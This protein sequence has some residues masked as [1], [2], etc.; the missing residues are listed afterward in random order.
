M[1]TEPVLGAAGFTSLI[2]ALF[3]LARIM[4]WVDLSDDQLAAWMAVV[5]IAA[6]M[7]SAFVARNRVTPTARPQIKTETGRTVPLVRADNKPLDS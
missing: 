7:T 6:S 1:K 2:A 4:G 3:A 5:L